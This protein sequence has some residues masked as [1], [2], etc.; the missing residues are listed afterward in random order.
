MDTSPSWKHSKSSNAP[1]RCCESPTHASGLAI[2][3]ADGVAADAACTVPVPVVGSA[4]AIACGGE[5][6]RWPAMNAARNVSCGAALDVDA[7]IDRRFVPTGDMAN[8][9]LGVRAALPKT[10]NGVRNHVP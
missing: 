10:V 9:V 2:D 7:S 6:G 3:A 4:A 8:K 5:C 1:Q